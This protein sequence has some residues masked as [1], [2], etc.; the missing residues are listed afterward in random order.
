M[1]LHCEDAA[2]LLTSDQFQDFREITG[3]FEEDVKR[4]EDLQLF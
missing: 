2:R 1:K 4:L 3:L